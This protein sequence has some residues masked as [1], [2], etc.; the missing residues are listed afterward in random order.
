MAQHSMAVQI[1]RFFNSAGPFDGLKC[2]LKEGGIRV[3]MIARWPG[4]IK[5]SS[6][7]EHA[8]SFDDVFPTICDIVGAD[9]PNDIT[10]IS[11]APELLGNEGQK[12]KEGPVLGIW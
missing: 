2:S 1:Q 9:K 6:V 12:S 8:S 11:F 7:S 3:P 10:G 5:A 4:K